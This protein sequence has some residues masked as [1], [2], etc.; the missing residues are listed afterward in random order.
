MTTTNETLTETMI[1]ASEAENSRLN[2]RKFLF[3]AGL[4][5]GAVA[6]AACAG[7]DDGD[8]NAGGDNG[9][10]GDKA[11]VTEGDLDVVAFAAGLEVLAVQTYQ[12]ALD[13]A[14]SGALGEIPDAGAEFVKTALAHHKEYVENFNAVLTGAGREEVTEPNAAVKSSVVDPALAAA[15]TF[16]DAA[17]LARTLET[18]ASATYLKAIQENL[19]GAGVLRTAGSIQIVNQQRIAILNFVLGTYPVPDV[20][21]KT[22]AAVAP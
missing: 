19:E 13:A 5:A 18:A 8:V 1:Q 7:D 2:R 20:F 9:D 22:D 3:G 11:D 4:A 12:A 14:T 15:K 21:Q 10:D 17:K 6:L 16:G